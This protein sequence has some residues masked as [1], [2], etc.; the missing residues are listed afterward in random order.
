MG[1]IKNQQL[2]HFTI[3]G[4]KTICG[5]SN[6]YKDAETLKRFT[7]MLNDASYKNTAAKNVKSIKPSHYNDHQRNQESTPT[8]AINT[9]LRLLAIS[10]Q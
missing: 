10:L 8:S 7:E 4:K 3:D 5:L 9:S 1:H 2:F 6:Q